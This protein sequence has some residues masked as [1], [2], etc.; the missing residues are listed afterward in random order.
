MEMAIKSIN[1]SI[2][3]PQKLQ[4]LRNKPRE[5]FK[6]I[7]SGKSKS[8]RKTR[9]GLETKLSRICNKVGPGKYPQVLPAAGKQV[10]GSVGHV[11]DMSVAFG[12]FQGRK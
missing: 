7:N 8:F 10:G 11:Q 9:S 6:K 1:K 12:V 2:T 5:V 3:Q 4:C